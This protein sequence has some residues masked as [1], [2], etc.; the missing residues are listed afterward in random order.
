MSAKQKTEKSPADALADYKPL[1][2]V[3][4]ERAD[5]GSLLAKGKLKHGLEIA[6]KKHHDFVMKEGFSDIMFDA[7]T[8]GMAHNLLTFNG[9]MM[10]RQLVSV[11]S[12]QGPFT[13]EMI[14]S[15]K[16]GDYQKLRAAQMELD[17][18]GEAE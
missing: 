14:G 8:E 12:F 9:L 11:G 7:E 15:L 1:Y 18:L 3:K 16:R 13:I 5:D 17:L 4:D 6:G 2:V 10:C